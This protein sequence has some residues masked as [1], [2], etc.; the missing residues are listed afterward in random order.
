MAI[1]HQ[2]GAKTI[3]R[4]W[5]ICVVHIYSDVVEFS[6]ETTWR[7]K[8]QDESNKFQFQRTNLTQLLLLYIH[9]AVEYF[10]PTLYSML[11]L[12]GFNSTPCCV[13]VSTL[14]IRLY[15]TRRFIRSQS[16]C[17]RTA[18]NTGQDTGPSDIT[19]SGSTPKP[20]LAVRHIVGSTCAFH[21]RN[22]SILKFVQLIC[23]QWD[24]VWNR[25]FPAVA[26]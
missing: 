26:R 6:L 13:M 3:I 7:A 24:D 9:D 10:Q 5:F 17:A 16:T 11:N 20:M 25:L 15:R 8:H 22:T 4:F 2:S 1:D 19:S 21:Y 18:G 14:G 12:M 23:V